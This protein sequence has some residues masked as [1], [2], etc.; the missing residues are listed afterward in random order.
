LEAWAHRL[1]VVSTFDPDGIVGENRLGV[2]ASSVE[3]LAAGLRELRRD[4]A[5]SRSLSQNGADYLAAHHA[6]EAVMQQF[7]RVLGDLVGTANLKHPNPVAGPR[8]DHPT[9]A[10]ACREPV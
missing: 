10:A 4:P 1:P 2:R 6:P 5:L 8:R 7:Q 9:R 3:G